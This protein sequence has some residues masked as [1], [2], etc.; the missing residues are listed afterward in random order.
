MA[1]LTVADNRMS[2]G[3]INVPAAF[4]NPFVQT[5][6]NSASASATAI[7]TAIVDVLPENRSLQ[8]PFGLP[9]PAP[10]VRVR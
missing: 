5:T 4:Y 1:S 10:R 8:Q 9:P 3:C 7:A 6:F 2:H